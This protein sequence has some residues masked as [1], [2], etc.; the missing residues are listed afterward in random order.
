MTTTPPRS[1]LLTPARWM[2]LPA[3]VLAGAVLGGGYGA[4][5]TPEY[6]ATSYVIVVPGEK[7]DPSAAL[8]FAQ[9]Y[10]RVATDIAVTGDAQVWAGVSADTLRQSVQASTSPDAPMISITA[11]SA[12]PAT[13]VSMADGV[14][15]ALVTNSTHVAANTGVKVV[16][17][18]RATKPQ[19]PVSPSA[20]LS[21]LVGGCA[22]GLLGG[23]ALLVRPKRTARAEARHSRQ[24]AAGGAAQVPGPAGAAAQQPEPEAV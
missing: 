10:G 23:L 20:P 18:S 19:Q 4:L 17:F 9:A 16:Q 5:K 15:R 14:A 24:P 7:S 13:A 8:G 1:S 6:A 22:G 2:V 12:K 21:A 3:A 11:R